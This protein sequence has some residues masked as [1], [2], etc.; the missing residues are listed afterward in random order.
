MSTTTTVPVSELV[1][2]DWQLAEENTERPT[3]LAV[4]LRRRAHILPYFRLIHAEGDDSQVRIVF[5]SHSV[6]ITGHGLEALLAAL[7]TQSVVRLVQPTE[8]EAKFGI[9]GLNATK[10]N[11]PAITGITVVRTEDEEE[12]Q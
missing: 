2:E 5:A 8:T 3:A 9:R 6:K 10:V 11:G 7:S 4:H 12:D 1:S